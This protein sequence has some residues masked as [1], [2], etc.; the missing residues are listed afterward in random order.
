MFVSNQFRKRRAARAFTLVELLVV[1]AII[2]ILLAM[3]LPAVQSV[4]EAARRATC[5]SNMRQVALA[6]QIHHDGHHHFPSGWKTLD[7]NDPKGEPG[8]GWAATILPHF[9]Q[10][11]VY[12]KIDFHQ[13]IGAEHNAEARETVIPSFRC[14]SDYAHAHF[15]LHSES[16]GSHLFEVARANY[17]GVF[18][19]EE[20]EDDPS[21]GD[22]TF[23][24]NSDIS[25]R[26]IRDGASQTIIVGERSSRSGDSTWVG[27]VAGA[28]EAF[29]RV[30]GTADHPPNQNLG[31]R[32]PHSH[33]EEEEEEEEEH[34]EEHHHLDDFSSDHPGGAHFV[35]G[36][37][38]VTF[39][40][41]DIDVEV[42]R[43]LA[44]RSGGEPIQGDFWGE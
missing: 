19:T 24:H 14:P 9:E 39:I 3:L 22:G 33:E 27:V 13:P 8:W 2:G 5:A 10:K 12:E 18:G 40:A 6:L 16:D 43:A 32:A 23:F 37:L 15:E 20:I 1:I 28:E 11:S 21:N 7:A 31:A 41:E 36:D 17:V 38:A 4:R 29:A 35:F 30:V 42:Y 44:T 34:E 26:K 25:I